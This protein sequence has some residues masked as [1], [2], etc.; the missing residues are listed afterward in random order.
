MTTPR[1]WVIASGNR[2]KL[3]E[4][5]RLFKPFTI[6]VK[7]QHEFA[8]PDAEE[9]GLS[10]IENAIIKA[11]NAAAYSGLPAIA[12]DSG[13][14]VDALQGQPGIYS[15]RFSRDEHG[16]SASDETNNQ[17]LLRL[18][19]GV[20]QEQRSARF[21]CALAFMRHAKDPT[22]VVCTGYWLGHILDAPC[23]ESGFGYDPLFYVSDQQCASAQLSPELKNTISHRAVAMQK[24]LTALQDE[25][26]I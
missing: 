25:K 26:V 3:A 18:L 22:P 1:Q 16:T 10:F 21:V 20:E 19:E 8:V 14:E 6:K 5:S 15:A 4:F 11:R 23:G 7:P 13:L 24:L 9:T 12:D 17:K 2:G